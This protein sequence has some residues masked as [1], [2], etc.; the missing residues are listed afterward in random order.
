[1]WARKR[2]VGFGFKDDTHNTSDPSSRVLELDYIWRPPVYFTVNYMPG[3]SS[4]R[5]RC[6]VPIMVAFSAG[7]RPV[8]RPGQNDSTAVHAISSV[9]ETI[10]IG[11]KRTT[12]RVRYSTGMMSL[13]TKRIV[14]CERYH[15]QKALV[16][17][18]PTL[19]RQDYYYCVP[20]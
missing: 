11:F 17:L 10:F 8:Y 14:R 16:V 7:S 19:T 2:V 5:Y 13:G 15:V 20:T 12:H 4:L 18:L 9:Y 1:M 6:T 3:T